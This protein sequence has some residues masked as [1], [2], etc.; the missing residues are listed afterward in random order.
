MLPT[1]F[2][3]LLFFFIFV[4]ACAVGFITTS[5]A[6]NS[7]GHN[8]L[9]IG[10]QIGSWKP[11]N[12]SDEPSVSPFGAKAARPYYGIFINSP[13]FGNFSIRASYGIWIFD[14]LHT[15]TIIPISLDLK[16]Q[17]IGQASFSPYV[18]YGVTLYLGTEKR[19]QGLCDLVDTE[20]QSGFGINLGVGFELCFLEHWRIL[21]EFDFHY[22]KFKEIIGI[23]S[24]YSGP[25]I[26]VG[27]MYIF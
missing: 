16:H 27:F 20:Y 14:E 11:N 13:S 3:K 1:S 7:T 4:I 25:K 5:F 12:L 26:M 15:A 9:G 17:L 19:P 24:D 18:C 10:F 8:G 2:K 22:A 21:S 23:T 6:Q